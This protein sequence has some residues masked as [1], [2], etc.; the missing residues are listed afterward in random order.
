MYVSELIDITKKIIHFPSGVYNVGTKKKLTKLE[1]GLLLAKKFQLKTDTIK[2]INYVDNKVVRPRDMSVNL[3]KIT[4]IFPKK[5][6]KISH[7]LELLFQD[8]KK[9]KK[10]LLKY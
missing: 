2:K 6:F 4:K 8:S 5:N 3:E 10:N 7:H 9:F 1:F